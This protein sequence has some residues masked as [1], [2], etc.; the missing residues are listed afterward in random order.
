M[1]LEQLLSEITAHVRKTKGS[2]DALRF[3]VDYIQPI[4]IYFGGDSEVKKLYLPAVIKRAPTWL[5]Y[6]GMIGLGYMIADI[7][8]IIY[9]MFL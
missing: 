2:G 4:K 6:L 8:F 5:D 7:A 3:Y 9:R 1:N